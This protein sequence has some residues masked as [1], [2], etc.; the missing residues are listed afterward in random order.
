VLADLTVGFNYASKFRKVSKFRGGR[1][2]H[3]S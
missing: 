1:A 2:T 3:A